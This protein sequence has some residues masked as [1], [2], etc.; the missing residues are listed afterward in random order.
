MNLNRRP[1]SDTAIPL[2]A[3]RPTGM[4]NVCPRAVLVKNVHSTF[5]QNSRKLDTGQVPID[6]RPDERTVGCASHHA[7][8]LGSKRAQISDT[9]NHVGESR[10][11]LC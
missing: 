8:A 11:T 9:C 10:L 7:A 4:K 6:R 3:T 2:L 5:I 1:V